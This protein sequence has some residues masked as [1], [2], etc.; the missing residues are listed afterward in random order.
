MART[1]E[2]SGVL[3]VRA[4]VEGAG[5]EGLRAQITQIRGCD[6]ERI[7][8]TAATVDQVLAAVRTWL[9]S[10]VSDPHCREP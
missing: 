7:E 8:T 1:R 6:E 3:A 4:W 2:R 5:S 9:E 10:L